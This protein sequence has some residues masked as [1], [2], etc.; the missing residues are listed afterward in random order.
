[1]K[2]NALALGLSR[3]LTGALLLASTAHAAEGS[4]DGGIGA[5]VELDRVEVTGGIVYR[6][7]A[8][9]PA[10]LVYDLAYFQQFE[11]LTV[12]DMLKRVPSIAFVSDVLEY[13]GARLRGLDPGY[14]QILINGKKVPGAGADRSFFVD[15][16]PAEMVERIEI[17]RSTSANRSGD[18]VAGAINIVLR[19]AY[20]FDGGYLRIGAMGFA[21]GEIKPNLGA[22]ISGDAGDGRYL[23]GFNHQGR[24]NPKQKRSDRFEEPGGD[25]VDAEDQSDTRDGDDTSVNASWRQEIGSGELSLSGMFVRTDRTETEH[26]LEYN[27]PLAAD[28]EHLL[29][30]NNQ[31]ETIEQENYALSLGY[32][33]DMAGGRS[34]I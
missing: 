10:T 8:D 20:E 17:V 32:E 23:L 34:E 2:R 22:V 33:F 3:A 4:A 11:P 14:T 21:D 26:S 13:D 6:D 1:M 12:G 9:E 18:A 30:E 5:A 7:R 19:N 27:D 15:R 29:S 24:Y 16:I 28:R 31:L 25:F